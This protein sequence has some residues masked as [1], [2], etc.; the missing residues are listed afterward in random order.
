MLLDA[1]AKEKFA[2]VYGEI[3]SAGTCYACG[4]MSASVFHSMR[5]V[6]LGLRIIARALGVTVTGDEQ[7]KNVIDQIE[8]AAKKLDDTPSRAGKKS[9]SQFFSEVAIHAYNVK[10]AWRNYVAHAKAEYTDDNALNILANV[11]RFY[12]KVSERFDQHATHGD[13]AT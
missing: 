6:E 1:A 5:A 11:Q 9:D 8:R 7:L 10:D 3:R 4:L 12:A 2:D 13:E